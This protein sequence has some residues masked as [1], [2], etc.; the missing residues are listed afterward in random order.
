[1]SCGSTACN[2]ANNLE[3]ASPSF[4]DLRWL[5]K[6]PLAWLAR[7]ALGVGTEVPAPATSQ[8]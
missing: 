3:A 1:M 7:T 6:I 8:T 2:S 5:W 4:P